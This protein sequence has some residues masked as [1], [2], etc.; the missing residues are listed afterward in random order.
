[1]A[2]EPYYD[3]FGRPYH[4]HLL[5]SGR[6][7]L[8]FVHART[9]PEG[10]VYRCPWDDTEAYMQQSMQQELFKPAEEQETVTIDVEEEEFTQMINM[11]H[12]DEAQD[13]RNTTGE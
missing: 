2:L 6:K 10:D 3:E 8:Y 11:L 1:M 9:T 13:K 12:L 7:K 5:G 4:Y